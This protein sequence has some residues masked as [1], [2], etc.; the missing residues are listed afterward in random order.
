MNSLLEYNVTRGCQEIIDL[1][2][3]KE[4]VGG[5]DGL[6]REGLGRDTSWVSQRINQPS[7]KVNPPQGGGTKPTG[8]LGTAG[9]PEK[10]R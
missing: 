7:E 5:K 4:V 6:I 8:P 10:K 1:P 9:L 3:K 2:E